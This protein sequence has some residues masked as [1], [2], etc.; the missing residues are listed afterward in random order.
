M[1]VVNFGEITVNGH[2]MKIEEIP[3]LTNL[4]LLELRSKALK[5]SE[6]LFIPYF[7]GNNGKKSWAFKNSNNLNQY[8]GERMKN[9]KVSNFG[10]IMFEGKLLDQTFVKNGPRKGICGGIFDKYLEIDFNEIMHHSINDWVFLVHRLV[11]ETWCNNIDS[12][13]YEDVH[14]LNNDLLDNRS[15]NLVWLTRWQHDEVHK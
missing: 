14:H 13:I 2:P 8:L 7:E 9:L 6:P 3:W 11:A 1:S 5:K 12:S 15:C 4:S 10:E